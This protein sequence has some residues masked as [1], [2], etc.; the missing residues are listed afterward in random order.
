M[1]KWLGNSWVFILVMGAYCAGLLAGAPLEFGNW[2]PGWEML[3]AI[4]TIAAT[5]T[6]LYFGTLDGRRRTKE[7]KVKA[8]I[9]AARNLVNLIRYRSEV[10]SMALWLVDARDN[11]AQYG[12]DWSVTVDDFLEL[13]IHISEADL[14]ALEG[15]D[16][17]ISVVVARAFA[18]VERSKALLQLNIFQLS[19]VARTRRL[20][21]VWTAL[22]G[23]EKLLETAID[24]CKAAVKPYAHVVTSF[25]D[26][27]STPLERE[28]NTSL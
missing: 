16:K 26:H 12:A 23:A 1:D 21:K 2:R 3:S 9:A 7:A 24:E 27:G 20:D 5:G 6:A 18:D 4:G 25:T 13:E 22:S 15:L 8:N 19:G 17:P 14:E 28:Q 11:W 10:Y